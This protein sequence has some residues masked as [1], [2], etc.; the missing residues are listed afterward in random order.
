MSGDHQL[1][2]DEIKRFARSYDPQP[3]HLD[4]EAARDSLFGGLAASGFHT[5]ATTMRLLVEGGLPLAGG[6]I[7]TGGELTWPK[8]TRPGD[9]L[10]VETEIL[11]VVP[12]RSR[13]GMGTAL[14]RCVTRNQHGEVVQT[15]S[16]RV[17]VMRRT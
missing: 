1:E 8:P 15:F 6:V 16:P 4:E 9:T 10:R 14:V 7:G 12:S 3:F 13:P 17:T 11:D 5:A 2:S